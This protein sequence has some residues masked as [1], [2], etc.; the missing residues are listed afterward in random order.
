[1]ENERL[2]RKKAT[3]GLEELGLHNNPEYVERLEFELKSIEEMGFV[4]YFLVMWDIARYARKNNILYGPGRGCLTGSTPVFMTNGRTKALKDIKP[5]DKVVCRDGSHRRV[6]LTHQYDVDEPLTT[7]HT[8]YGDFQGITATRD[9]RVYSEKV[10]IS[11]DWER[12]PNSRNQLRRFEEPN[13]KIDLHPVGELR[14]GDWIFFPVPEREEVLHGPIDLLPYAHSSKYVCTLEGSTIVETVPKSDSFVG[15][16]RDI[17]RQTGV[18]RGAIKRFREA[19]KN[20][21]TYAS[22]RQE[23]AWNKIQSYLLGNFDSLVE[24]EKSVNQNRSTKRTTSRYIQFD[25]ELMW[26]L[27]KWTADGWLKSVGRLL[28]YSRSRTDRTSRVLAR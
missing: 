26:V 28:S 23:E 3:E 12:L 7:I 11:K 14:E 13:G 1:M 27:G 18:S 4:P 20:H 24:W 10:S 5:F 9:H 2:L 16:T 15:S 17:C 22:K 6:L 19:W 25:S 8:Y 21:E